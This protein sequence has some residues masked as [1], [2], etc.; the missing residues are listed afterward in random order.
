MSNI[1][2]ID[3]N[4]AMLL[5]IAIFNCLTA[6][7]SMRNHNAIKKVA[8]DV[9]TVELAT[10]SMKDQLVAATDKAS[11][12]EGM[13][14]GLQ[15]GRDENNNTTKSDA[16]AVTATENTKATVDNTKAVRDNTTR[17]DKPR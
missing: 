1:T 9:K 16:A 15:Q 13:A 10:N 6:F 14:I 7:L 11:R 12:A 3:M 2:Q 8:N 4:T 17:R 5:G